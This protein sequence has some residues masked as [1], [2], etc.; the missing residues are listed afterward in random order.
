[1][2]TNHLRSLAKVLARLQGEKFSGA[3]IMRAEWSAGTD[4]RQVE[5][6]Q[7][8]KDRHNLMRVCCKACGEQLLVTML[9]GHKP[10][11]DVDLSKVDQSDLTSQQTEL[12]RWEVSAAEVWGFTAAVGD[13][14]IIHQ[15]ETPVIPG[16]LLLEKLLAQRP[17][18]TAKLSM[19]FS[20]AAYA[21]FVFVDWSKGRFLQGKR[22]T[23]S[24]AWQ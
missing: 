6:L 7:V 9:L 1:M 23:A 10:Q 12:E 3:A 16:L 14:N 18:G 11:Q 2:S 8:L 19:R 20:H 13:T 24:F 4:R 22:C 21:G 5:E 17:A 15:R